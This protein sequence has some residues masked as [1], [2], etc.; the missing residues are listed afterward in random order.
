M[1]AAKLANLKDGQRAD[2][3][4]GTPIGAAASM[5]NVGRKSVER[6]RKVRDKGTPELVEAVEPVSDKGANLHPS[7]EAAAALNAFQRSARS[8]VDRAGRNWYGANEA[9]AGR[10]VSSKGVTPAL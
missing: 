10:S 8:A 3:V 5:L 9:A 6:A 2:R 1:A 7:A 4:Q